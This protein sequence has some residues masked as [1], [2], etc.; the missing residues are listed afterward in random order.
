[1]AQG[2]GVPHKYTEAN[3]V[4]NFQDLVFVLFVAEG[5]VSVCMFGVTYQTALTRR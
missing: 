3:S 1:M 5:L 2:Q 4:I